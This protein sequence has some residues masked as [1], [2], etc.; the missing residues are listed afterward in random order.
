MWNWSRM[1]DDIAAYGWRNIPQLTRILTEYVYPTEVRDADGSK[2]RNPMQL[3]LEREGKHIHYLDLDIT[4][5]NNGIFHTTLYN[6]RDHLEALHDYREFAH[7]SSLIS[8][9]AKYG[10][11]TSA[12]HR[13]ARLSSTPSG[14]T[15]NAIRLLRKMVTHGYRYER[16]R[17]QLYSFKAS[18]Q[19][20]QLQIFHTRRSQSIG[21]IW[22]RLMRTVNRDRRRRKHITNSLRR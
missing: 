4:V 7:I 5:L 13:F 1:I 2:V 15:V 12:L 6:K 11:Y 3:N 19:W 8:N 9:T 20:A 16:L 22:R 21:Y 10:V 17:S 18:Y 14:F